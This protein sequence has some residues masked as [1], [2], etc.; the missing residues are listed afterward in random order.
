[1]NE[2]SPGELPLAPS[3]DNSVRHEGAEDL[4]MEVPP[5]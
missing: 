1:M 5:E 2:P 4:W 3:P